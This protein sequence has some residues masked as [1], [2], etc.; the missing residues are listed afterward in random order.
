MKPLGKF[1]V[2]WGGGGGLFVCFL[3]GVDITLLCWSDLLISFL[4]EKKLDT[5]PWTSRSQRNP[6][7]W[8]EERQTLLR[9]AFKGWKWKERFGN[10]HCAHLFWD[11][12]K[13]RYLETGKRAGQRWEPLLPREGISLPENR[14]SSKFP[15]PLVLTH[16]LCHSPF[17]KFIV[18]IIQDR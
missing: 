13:P 12:L 18:I 17:F 8:W 1:F 6:V 16:E 11:H 15:G 7:Y 3:Q 14:N 10:S 4:E 9:C 2:F 5:A